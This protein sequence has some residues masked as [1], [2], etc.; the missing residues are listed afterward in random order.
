MLSNHH[1][2]LLNFHRML[3]W[4]H[5]MN[6][7]HWHSILSSQYNTRNPIEH[8][9]SSHYILHTAAKYPYNAVKSPYIPAPCRHN[10]H[11]TSRQASQRYQI[12]TN[13]YKKYYLQ[14]SNNQIILSNSHLMISNHHIIWSNCNVKVVNC[15]IIPSNYHT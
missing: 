11:Q 7:Q 3:T 10:R 8:K 15:H 2:M 9:L 6:L 12:T 4:N 5:H 14:V 1:M 13:W